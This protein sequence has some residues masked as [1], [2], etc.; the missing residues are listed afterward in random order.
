MNLASASTLKRT[1]F[2]I[3]NMDT[4]FR[5]RLVELIQASGK[6]QSEIA[7]AAHVSQGLI[8]QWKNGTTKEPEARKVSDVCRALGNVNPDYLLH[9]RMPKYLGE[10]AQDAGLSIPPGASVIA[11]EDHRDLSPDSYLFVARYDVSLSAGTGNF[12]WIE[13]EEDPI[14]FRARFFQARG[15][16]P[17]NCRALA[18]RGRSMEPALEDGDAVMIDI[19]DT[20]I[21]DGEMYAVM[22][23]GELFIKYIYRRGGGIRLKS[24]NPEFEPID[25]AGEQLDE[26]RIIGKKV[27]R[28]G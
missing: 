18:V 9:G 8:T 23:Q 25:I 13:H 3:L 26:L 22:Y 12:V 20:R 14:A 15:L 24:A 1:G 19:S 17:E 21:V 7:A 2:S 11:Y 10:Q 4:G 28:A 5:S 6:K 27:W 16:K